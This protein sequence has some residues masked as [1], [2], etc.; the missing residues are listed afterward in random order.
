MTANIKFAKTHPDAVIP[1][2]RLEDMGFDIYACFDEDYI[3]IP[4]HES[5][6]IP[7]GIAS[8]CDHG[9][10]FLLRERGSTGVKNIKISAGV[11]DS[12]FR[13]SWFVCLYNGNDIP[14]Y[15]AKYLDGEQSPCNDNAII[16]PYEKAIAQALVVP[17]PEVE[18][19]EIAYTVLQNIPSERGMGQLGSSLK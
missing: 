3:E 16:Y 15:I 7:T 14:V 17:V 10:G 1:S 6:L 4:A 13:N 18:V 9:Y 2:K 5:K 19:E 12:G 8:V 11:I